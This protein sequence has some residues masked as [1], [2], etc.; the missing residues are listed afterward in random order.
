MTSDTPPVQTYRQ[1]TSETVFHLK[2]DPQVPVLI[3]EID[4]LMGG[5]MDTPPLE[6]KLTPSRSATV[7][8]FERSQAHG[9]ESGYRTRVRESP[10]K[11][12]DDEV[13]TSEIPFPKNINPA[14]FMR[15]EDIKID[16]RNFLNTPSPE[17]ALLDMKGAPSTGSSAGTARAGAYQRSS[18]IGG[19]LSHVS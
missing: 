8:S 9:T 10:L 19:T 12:N 18:L 2:N 1:P 6:S 11:H 5:L 15:D 13:F 4:E 3:Q 16:P 14:D 7:P 17:P